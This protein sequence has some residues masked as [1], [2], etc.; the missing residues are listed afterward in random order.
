MNKIILNITKTGT[1][2]I[3]M[4]LGFSNAKSQQSMPIAKIDSETSRKGEI[5]WVDLVTNDAKASKKFF[6]GLLGWDFKD[7]DAYHLAMSGSKPVTGIIEDKELLAGSKTSYW[8]VSVSVKN[9]G[10]TIKKITSKGG[11]VVSEPMEIPG[12]GIVALV[13]DSQGAFFS[14]IYNS[15]GDPKASAPK[16]G[17]WLWAELWTADPKGAVS[18]YTDVLSISAKPLS[19]NGAENYFILKGDTYDFAGITETPVKDEDPIWIPV[20]RVADAEAIANKAV[21]LGG[22]ILINPVTVSGKKVALIATPFGA[23][24]LIQEWKD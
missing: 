23:P 6:T 1:L 3:L 5:V 13:E 11:K 21:D 9:I 8:V 12:R 20:L 14:L 18:F 2:L 15:S 17:E 4:L 19:D 10:K 16:N 24:F 22:S 7:H